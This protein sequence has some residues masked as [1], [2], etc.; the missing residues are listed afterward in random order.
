MS[1]LLLKHGYGPASGD[2]RAGSGELRLNFVE[3][4]M[5]GDLRQN[6]AQLLHSWLNTSRR[7]AAMLARRFAIVCVMTMIFG[8]MLSM[9]VAETTRGRVN[10]ASSISCTW[11]NDYACRWDKP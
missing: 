11:S 9:V 1:V 7:T 6:S 4:R 8:M 2:N 3:R 5:N 10:D